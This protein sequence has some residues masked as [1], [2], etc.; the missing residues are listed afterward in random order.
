MDTNGLAIVRAR[1]LI[2]KAG[3]DFDRLLNWHLCFGLVV[4]SRDAFSMGRITNRTN[5]S[6]TCDDGDTLYVSMAVGDLS[7]LN[8]LIPVSVK[9]IAWAR[10][11][12]R[13][14]M[15]CGVYDLRRFR[16]LCDCGVWY[17]C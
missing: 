17:N 14:N 15:N 7:L 13:G 11:A 3:G 9:F 5:L 4:S 8:R 16:S 12:K 2:N 1:D 10:W 6:S